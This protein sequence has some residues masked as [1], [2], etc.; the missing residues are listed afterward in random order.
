[1][2]L[3]MWIWAMLPLLACAGNLDSYFARNG[4]NFLIPQLRYMA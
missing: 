1:M 4:L 2:S 3:F